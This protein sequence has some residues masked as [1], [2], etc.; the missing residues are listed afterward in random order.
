MR[1]GHDGDNPNLKLVYDDNHA[2]GDRWDTVIELG[3]LQDKHNGNGNYPTYQTGNGYGMYMQSNSDGAYFGLEEYSTGNFRPVVAW[4]DDSTDSPFNFKYNNSIKFQ[5]DYAGNFTASQNVTAYSDIKLK[6]NIDIITQPIEKV[7]AL[8]GVSYNRNDVPGNP[9]QVGVIAQE[10]EKVLP[11][12]VSYNEE[13]DTK[14]VAYGNMVGLLIEAI[15][16]QQE[17]IEA[18]KSEINSLKGGQ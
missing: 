9:R 13:T 17:Q 8:R 11:E 5:F 6:D 7:K 14:S 12:V 1:L 2:N 18:L 3:R 16:E 4:G 15:K 10:V